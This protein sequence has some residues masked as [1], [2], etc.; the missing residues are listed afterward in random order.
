MTDDTESRRLVT[1]QSIDAS[2]RLAAASTDRARE[3]TLDVSERLL[4]DEIRALR[5]PLESMDKALREG[6]MWPEIAALR[7][8][9]GE[10]AGIRTRLDSL[11]AIQNELRYHGQ[12]LSAIEKRLATLAET[13][14]AAPG[15]PL[16]SPPSQGGD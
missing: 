13:R 16:S 7:E 11:V 8:L 2:N 12:R 4:L 3:L 6:G 14:L 1:Q 5:E 10:L 9:R 15:P